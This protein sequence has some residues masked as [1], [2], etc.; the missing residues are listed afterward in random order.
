MT[1]RYLEGSR[2]AE[3]WAGMYITRGTHKLGCGVQAVVALDG[4][5]AASER[6]EDV[7]RRLAQG[8]FQIK[9]AERV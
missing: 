5:W 4:L 1:G 3:R 9:D 2:R 8:F 6:R 7:A